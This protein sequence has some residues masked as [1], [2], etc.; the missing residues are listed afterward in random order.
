MYKIYIKNMVCPRCVD[1]VC[2]ALNDEDVVYYSVKL[3][4]AD[5]KEIPSGRNLRKL[6]KNLKK[7]GFE[8]L[9]DKDTELVNVVK[10]YLI[11]KIHYSQNSDSKQNVSEKLSTLLK[12]DYSTI[13]RTF[14]KVEKN[15]IEHFIKTQKIEKVKELISYDQLNLSEIAYE[16][17][18]SSISH[19]SNQFKDLVGMSPSEFKKLNEKPRSFLDEL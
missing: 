1:S 18:Y 9:V 13:S 5:I 15:T 17:G 19:L 8:Y 10:S 6:K 12:K 11:D 4:E 3:G 14:S 16:V 2:D 7:R